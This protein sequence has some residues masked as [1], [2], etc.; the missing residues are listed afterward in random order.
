MGTVRGSL[1]RTLGHPKIKDV[2]W[3]AFQTEY[4]TLILYYNKANKVNRI[5][6]SSKPTDY[7]Q[8]CN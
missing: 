6:F 1:F 3:D 5:Q 2:T 7:I 8:L 4:G